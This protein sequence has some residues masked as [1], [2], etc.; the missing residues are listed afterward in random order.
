MKKLS[1]QYARS[2]MF[3]HS[4]EKGRKGTAPPVRNTLD[5]QSLPDA[6]EPQYR[7]ADMPEQEQQPAQSRKAKQQ[8]PK[9]KEEKEPEILYTP[10]KQM[11]KDK[12]RHAALSV[13]VSDE[14]AF[15]LRQ[16]ASSLGSGFSKWARDT[17][18]RAMGR[19]VPARPKRD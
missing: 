4:K 14:E 13:C 2:R 1:Q 5:V 19:K 10:P 11:K 7:P 18:F 17:L 3:G 16:H 15:L 8:A 6:W 12:R 9:P